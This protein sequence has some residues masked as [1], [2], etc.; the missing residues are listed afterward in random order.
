M[1]VYYFKVI[2]PDH[3]FMLCRRFAAPLLHALRRLCFT[4]AAPFAPGLAAPFTQALLH[5]SCTLTAHRPG[6]RPPSS[7]QLWFVWPCC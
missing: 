6:W 1:L 5:L 3:L 4:L 2:L 7:Q